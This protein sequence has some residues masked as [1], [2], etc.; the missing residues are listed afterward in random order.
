MTTPPAYRSKL[1]E[2]D[3]PLNEINLESRKD[4]SQVSGHPSTL[5]KYWA[6]RPLAAGAIAS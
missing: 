3:L 4:A 6:R 1:I 5:H 2:I